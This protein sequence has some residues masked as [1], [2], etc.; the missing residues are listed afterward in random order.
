LKVLIKD[1]EISLISTILFLEINVKT[2]LS[3]KSLY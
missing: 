2:D 3:S 1:L